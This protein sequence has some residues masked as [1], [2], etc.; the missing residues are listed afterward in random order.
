MKQRF[1]L[2]LAGILS[3]ICLIIFST[4]AAAQTV[5]VDA[6]D[7]VPNTNTFT[8]IATTTVTW[9]C[10]FS[11]APNNEFNSSFSITDS[12]GDTIVSS[13][14]TDSGSI[15]EPAGAY[16][17]TAFGG[18]Y[19]PHGPVYGTVTGSVTYTINDTTPPTVTITSPT[20]N[21]QVGGTILIQAAASDNIGITKI[22]F[23][24]D[25][26]LFQTATT[27]PYQC[28]WDTTWY[29]GSHTIKAIAYDPALN[30]GSYSVPVTLD[31]QAY[32]V[33]SDN[34]APQSVT[35]CPPLCVMVNYQYDLSRAITISNYGSFTIATS[36]GAVVNYL[37]GSG[38]GSFLAQA[39]T[40]YTMSVNGGSAGNEGAVAYGSGSGAVNYLLE[41]RI[42]PTVA[43]TSPANGSF[44]KGS[45]T[46][47]INAHDENEVAGTALYLDGKLLSSDLIDTTAYPNGSCHTLQ[48]KATDE[49]GNVGTSNLI[50]IT[51]DNQPPSLTI[52]SPAA[53]SRV[54]DTVTIQATA[55]DNIGVVKIELYIDGSLVN[56]LTS[57]PYQYSWN[58]T[59]LSGSHTIQMIAYDPAGN[60][61]TQ[62]ETV[63]LDHITRSLTAANGAPSQ[64]NFVV[65]GSGVV[66]WQ[67]NYNATIYNSAPYFNILD[68][69]SNTIVAQLS[70]GSGSFTAQTGTT[71]TINAYGGSYNLAPSGMIYGT[72][73]GSVSFSDIT[74]PTVNILINNNTAVNNTVLNGPLTVT[75][76][77]LDD[78]GIANVTKLTLLNSSGQGIL[79]LLANSSFGS[80]QYPDGNYAIQAIA[81]DDA[82]NQATATVNVTFANTPVLTVANTNLKP[83][84]AVWTHNPVTLN[85]TNITINN[86]TYKIFDCVSGTAVDVTQSLT[87]QASLST[88]SVTFANSLSQGKHVLY[89]QTADQFN[90]TSN[91]YILNID[92][93]APVINSVSIDQ[94]NPYTNNPDLDYRFLRR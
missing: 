76:S 16:T 37:S 49:A 73:T 87:N 5:S 68:N 74:P 25:N 27:P 61:A 6:T 9:Q 91:Q 58:T 30:T 20:A 55:T 67:C 8:L 53:N 60:T 50:N 62:T 52:T 51:V 15:T 4:S 84:G 80:D 44:V 7:G 79:D 81:Y 14:A 47:N 56:T 57:P 12:K 63:T 66:N 23:Y 83:D 21:A 46:V 26:V 42:P 94:G 29:G 19:S 45:I 1:K 10:D 85:C 2:F 43:I 65:S 69:N 92:D 82:M 22:E 89:I 36:G 39:G 72:M 11:R 41:D 31:H 40:T 71:Y 59:W 75:A 38:T 93:N 70:S 48:A 64:I 17:I 28:S 32:S 34:G 88:D 90:N 54:S 13:T 77:A 18:T 24:L 3:L 86:R 33:S 78:N 35:F